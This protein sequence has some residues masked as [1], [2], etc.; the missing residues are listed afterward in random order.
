MGIDMKITLGFDV[1]IDQSVPGHLIEHVIKETDSGRQTRLSVTIEVEFDLD[2][3]L[4]GVASD[5]CLAHCQR[6]FERTA[7]L[8]QI[9]TCRRPAKRR[10]AYSS[11][12]RNATR[13]AS[14]CASVPTLIRRCCAIRAG[15]LK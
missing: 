10:D 7:I 14:H 5:F 12:S 3:R 4:Q 9:R 2:F 1:Q 15:L 11:I 13:K 6:F 8:T